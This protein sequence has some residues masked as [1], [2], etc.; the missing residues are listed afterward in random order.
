MTALPNSGRAV[1]YKI[2]FFFL[3]YFGNSVFFNNFALK[4]LTT[5]K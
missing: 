3:N 4:F 5:Y 2:R 1:F